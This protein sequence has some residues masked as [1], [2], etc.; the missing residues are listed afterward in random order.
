MRTRGTAVIIDPGDDAEYII[1][2]VTRLNLRPMAILATHGHFDHV[3]AGFALQHTYS[4]PFYLSP[5]D[6]FLLDGMEAS[7]KHFWECPV[8]IR[9]QS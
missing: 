7:A 6:Q 3:M 2:T 9:R 4:I 1:D 8:Q 5:S